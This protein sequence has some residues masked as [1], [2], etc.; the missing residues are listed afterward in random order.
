VAARPVPMATLSVDRRYA[1]VSHVCDTEILTR[2]LL[3]K[4][5]CAQMSNCLSKVAAR[6]H[7]CE[8]TAAPCVADGWVGDST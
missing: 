4:H 8:A 7:P 3:R 5:G 6:R 1:W 2:G